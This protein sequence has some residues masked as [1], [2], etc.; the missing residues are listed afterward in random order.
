MKNKL[1]KTI[2]ELKVVIF[3]VDGVLTDGKII[4]DGKG[5]EIKAFNV[6]DGF[7]ISLLRKSGI[8]TAIITAKSSEAVTARGKDLKI[9]KVYQDAFPKINAYK[10][11]LE[12]FKV[13]SK[14]TCFIGDDIPDVCVLRE[15]GFAVAVNN[16]PKEVKDEADYVTK[17]KGGEGAVREVIEFIL[18]TQGKWEGI[19]K[20]I[21]EG[22]KL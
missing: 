6:A 19:I 18:K 20:A 11:V 15:V 7:G 9:D 12:D 17:R 14:E 8:K 16:A 2:E 3:D 4:M 10:N 21:C 13:A 5:N 1:K 22:R